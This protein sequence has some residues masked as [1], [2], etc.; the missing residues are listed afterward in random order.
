MCLESAEVLVEDN[1]EIKSLRLKSSKEKESEEIVCLFEAFPFIGHILRMSR[2][3]CR[4]FPI[5]TQTKCP[6]TDLHDPPPLTLHT[7]W[8]CVC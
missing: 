7:M 1:T 8:S 2:H 6:S 5:H 3:L 4:S